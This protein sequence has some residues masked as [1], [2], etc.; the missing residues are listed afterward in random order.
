MRAFVAV[1]LVVF[2]LLPITNAQP[3]I[4]VFEGR[5]QI[6]ETLIVGEY[7]IMVTLEKREMRPYAIVYENN[8][9]KKIVGQW[10][11]TEVGDFR[12]ILGS[13]DAEGQDVFVSLQYKPSLVK[14]L[15][16]REGFSFEVGG[17]PITIVKSSSEKLSLKVDGKEV[18]VKAN[19][20]KIYDKLALE[21]ANGILKVY[22][23]KVE[24][25]KEE[26]EA[27][28]IYYP[29]TRLKVKAGDQVQIPIEVRNN[30]NND[31]NLQL[32]VISKPLGWAVEL[33]NEMGTYEVS[34]ISL[35]PGASE[36]LNLLI[37]VPEGAS[38]TKIV[39]FAVGEEAGEIILDV[40]K[41][42][43][44]DVVIPMLSIEC[45]A[46]QSVAFPITLSGE[47]TV[48]LEIK[49]KPEDWSAYFIL[50]NQRVRSFL[51]NG[52][53][54]VTL[55]VEVPRDAELGEHSISFSVNGV[56]KSVSVFVYKTHKGEPAKLHI[57]VKDEEGS[58]L[59]KAEIHIGSKTLF[60]DSY[61][62]V[63]VEIK[64]GMYRVIVE[65]EG[66]EKSEKEVTVEAG[67]EKA[68][69]V[70]LAK[71]PYYFELEGSGDTVA[72]TT[73]SI[74]TYQLG[75][76]N[77]G[78]AEDTYSLSLLG[79]PEGWSAE[80]YYAESPARSIKINSGESKEVTLRIIPPFNAQPGE[81][82]LT[83]VVRSS[84]GLQKEMDL[85]VKLI[86]EYRLEMYPETPT[87]SIKASGD[88]VAYVSL[89]NA[90]TAPTTN[91]K[92]E[93]SAP[94]GWDVEVAPQVIPELRSRYYSEKGGRSVTQVGIRERL[95]VTIKVPETTPAGTYQITI[96]GKGDQAQASTQ[97]TVRV[98][99]SSSSAYIGV[100]LLVL[101]FVAVAWMI[102]RVGRR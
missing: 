65:K 88:G 56:E 21:Y 53:E 84:S 34:E 75:I 45:E 68:L 48:N 81:Y 46:G 61:G 63:T 33:F 44:V 59:Q 54:Q 36:I 15:R 100:F 67:E 57:T 5:V 35:K 71:L 51:L 91:I 43:S 28:K 11:L 47:G 99:Q 86:G 13:Y 39:R 6:G 37:K 9:I 4:T 20:T 31:L 78:K 96:T 74:G 50:N 3:W 64:P 10:N 92:F 52:K 85:M 16:P 77:I 62:K 76:R 90:G 22:Y 32:S 2:S 26:K 12:I 66:Y 18:E 1:F 70:T 83:I 8:E 14:E 30:G 95:T 19:S 93:V 7:Q 87:V 98:T 102:R 80:F 94:Q 29:F 72:V 38:G 101:T 82:N 40:I 41:N 60:T 25:E 23:A 69:E 17:H 49:E 24:V 55:F 42:S 89:E 58:P 27:Y 97:I 79:I 73:G